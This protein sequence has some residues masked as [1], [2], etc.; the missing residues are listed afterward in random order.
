V[1]MPLREAVYRCVCTDSVPLILV[2]FIS[3][4][5]LCLTLTLHLYSLV[6]FIEIKSRGSM[7]SVGE[8]TGFEVI[9]IRPLDVG[10]TDQ[11]QATIIRPD[12]TKFSMSID[13]C[14]RSRTD[15]PR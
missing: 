6:T 15:N 10:F 1:E 7:L 2:F 9:R 8:Q 4:P 13:S 5:L 3:L 14:L 11:S 12:G